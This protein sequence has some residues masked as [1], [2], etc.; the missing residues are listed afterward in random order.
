MMLQKFWNG[1]D[2]KYVSDESPCRFYRKADIL[3]VTF[4]ADI[5][6]NVGSAALEHCKKLSAMI[7]V[8][9]YAT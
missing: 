6:N 3:P 1:Y 2:G 4:N 9:S 5:N 7:F 8:M